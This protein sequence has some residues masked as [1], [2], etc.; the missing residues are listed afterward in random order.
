VGFCLIAVLAGLAF[1]PQA[2]IPAS[3]RTSVLAE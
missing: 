3:D 1:S 2:A